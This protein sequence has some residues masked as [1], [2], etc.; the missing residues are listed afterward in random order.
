MSRNNNVYSCIKYI[1]HV[2][3]T[4]N[5]KLHRLLSDNDDNDNDDDKYSTHS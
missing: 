4:R 1:F 3:S 2:C 5:R